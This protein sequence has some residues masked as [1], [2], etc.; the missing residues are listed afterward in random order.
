M[1][2][3]DIDKEVERVGRVGSVAEIRAIVLRELHW[4]YNEIAVAPDQAV[5]IQTHFNMGHG[6]QDGMVRYELVTTVAGVI[7]GHELFSFEAKHNAFFAVPADHEFSDQEL[8]AFG[9][10]TAFFML[11]PYVRETLHTQT[12]NAGIPPVI[13]APL[14]MPFEIGDDLKGTKAP[15]SS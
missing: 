11:F 10:I 13:L 9:R 15:P 1:I 14:R 6:H 12:T 2:K 7:P 3:I 8:T 5:E 4:V